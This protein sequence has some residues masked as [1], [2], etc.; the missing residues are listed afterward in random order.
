MSCVFYKYNG[1]IFSGD[2]WCTKKDCRVDSDTYYQYCR[3]YNYDACPI[4]KHQESSGCFIT[5]IIC[6]ILRKKDDDVILQTLR[7]FRD[8]YLQK[9]EEY[10]NILKEYDTIGPIIADCIAND[11]YKELVVWETY[12]KS[13]IPIYYFIRQKKYE[14]AIT[15]YQLMTQLLIDYY[16]LNEEYTKIKNQNYNYDDFVP[17]TAGHGKRR[18]K[19]IEINQSL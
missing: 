12:E 8:N 5:T 15:R 16:S 7:N 13:L 2:Y 9:N 18:A 11:K 1:G 10:Y 17:E 4:Y 19:S 14:E 6:N 3:D